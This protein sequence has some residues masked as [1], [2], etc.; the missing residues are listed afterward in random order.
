MG[1]LRLASLL[2]LLAVGGVPHALPPG[3]PLRVTVLHVVDGD[4]IRVRL[5]GGPTPVRL[6]GIDAP[7]EHESDRLDRAA[8]RSHRSKA[9]IQALGRLATDFT[10]QHL[11][12]RSV[13]LELDAERRD[14]YGRLLAYVWL[15]E[16]KLFNAEIGAAASGAGADAGPAPTCRG[17]L[18]SPS[19]AARR[20]RPP[21]CRARRP[22]GRP[23]RP[24]R[25]PG[26]HRSRT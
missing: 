21:P 10:R 9:S 11:L 12:G 17:P 22:P 2:G 7:E 19:P 5:P 6:I 1:D 4:T 15:D 13:S 25:S 23:S 16:R 8:R 26:A 18:A 20:H 3:S 24:S 14:R